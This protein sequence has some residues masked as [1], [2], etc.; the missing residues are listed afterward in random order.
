[1]AGRNHQLC[2]VFPPDISAHQLTTI[3][4]TSPDRSNADGA[5]ANQLLRISSRST[6][7]PCLQ[8]AFCVAPNVG[9]IQI[10]NPQP[11]ASGAE[12]ITI[13]YAQRLFTGMCRRT[14]KYECCDNSG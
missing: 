14:Y 2:K 5:T 8:G 6:A 7:P 1:M 4:I 3:A 9:R 10:F 11:V 13:N 12:R